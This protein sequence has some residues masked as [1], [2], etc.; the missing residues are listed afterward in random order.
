MSIA[1]IALSLL[2]FQNIQKGKEPEKSRRLARIGLIAGVAGLILTSLRWIHYIY[3]GVN[4][5]NF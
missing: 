3:P 4:I 5:F 2:V 1:A